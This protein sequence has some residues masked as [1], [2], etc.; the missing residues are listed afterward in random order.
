METP[1]PSFIQLLFAWIDQ[2]RVIFI[3]AAN[4]L[5]LFATILFA[6]L[7]IRPESFSPPV[8]EAASPSRMERSAPAPATRAA[9]RSGSAGESAS[10]A[11]KPPRRWIRRAHTGAGGE[12]LA[13]LR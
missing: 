5:V 11:P 6:S 2:R 8:A 9:R 13:P 10:T 1:S 12:D 7:W 4:S 3:S